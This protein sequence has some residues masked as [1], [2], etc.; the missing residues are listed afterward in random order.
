MDFWSFTQYP[1]HL[2][3]NTNQSVYEVFEHQ[4]TDLLLH[5]VANLPDTERVMVFLRGRE[6][7][8]KATTELVNAG[9]DVDSIHGKMKVVFRE[10]AFKNFKEG[11]VRVLVATDAAA[12]GYDLAGIEN[13]INFD[14]AELEA[15]YNQRVECTEQ[16]G[17]K[18][19][20]LMLKKEHKMLDRLEKWVGEALPQEQAEGFEYD[21]QP[22][23]M[24]LAN[25]MNIKKT[26]TEKSKPLQ[27]KKS[28]LRNKYGK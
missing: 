18:S 6:D 10:E 14:F 7:V 4:K 9:E 8:H 23:P 22:I 28:K 20:T 13:V 2:M 16:A 15:D 26:K 21:K 27:N 12:R 25:R 1:S 11:K 5:L 3:S 19:I 17:G 24:K